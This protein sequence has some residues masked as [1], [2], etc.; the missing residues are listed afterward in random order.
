MSLRLR[1]FPLIVVQRPVSFHDGFGSARRRS[2]LGHSAIDI[3]AP[4]GTTVVSTTGGT[5]VRSWERRRDRRRETGSGWSDAGGN[6]VVIDDGLGYAHYYAHMRDRPHV[7][8]GDRVMPGQVLGFVSNQGSAARGGPIHLHYQ[9]WAIG[10]GRREEAASG[11]YTRPFGVDVNPY[12]QLRDLAVGLGAR[13]GRSGGV[14][15]R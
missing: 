2:G 15:F 1:C 13:A 10:A 11:E 12:E 9:V 6:I 4:E 8:P 14:F 5:V 3:G 7:S